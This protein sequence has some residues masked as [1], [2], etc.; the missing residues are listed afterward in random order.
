MTAAKAGA[1]PDPETAWTEIELRAAEAVVRRLQA[2]IVKATQAGRWNKVQALQHLLTHSHSAKILAVARVVENQGRKTPGVDGETWLTP[3]KQRQAVTRL[4]RRGYGPQPL[5]RVY[6]PKSNGQRRPLGIPTMLDRALQALYLQALD[7]VAET[8]ADPHSYGFRRGRS[9]H[10]ALEQCFNVLAGPKAPE[11]VLEGDIEACFDRLDHAW[12]LA[13]VP[14]RGAPL[15][16]WL[17][18]G[19]LERHVLHPTEEGCPQGG[20]I[21]PVLANLALDGLAATLAA[22]FPPACRQPSPKVHLVRYADDFVI[23]GPSR[24]VLEH[25]VR[26]VVEAFLAERGLRLSPTKTVITHIR[27]GFDFLGQNVRKYG[28][29]RTVPGSGKLL[30]RPSRKSIHRLLTD[31]RQWL[32]THAGATSEF[33]IAWFNPKL[34]G[35]ANYHGHG[36]SKATFNQIDHQM[37]GMLWRW[38]KRRHP[39]KNRTWIKAKYFTTV[40]GNRWV[41]FGKEGG[42]AGQ[43][44]YVLL[45][46]MGRTRITR[47]VKVRSRLNPYATEWQEYQEQRAHRAARQRLASGSIDNPTHEAWAAYTQSVQAR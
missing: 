21:S 10:D 2:R 39:Q 11:W 8:Q 40:G 33:V 15:Q 25:E 35:W 41:F 30:L 47:H 32:K 38:A 29:N 23:T 34:R 31:F 44:R 4:R 5:R 27:T 6:I 17:K 1:A 19:Y 12:L 9:C 16:A 22:R 20:I 45:Y 14:L 46:Q 13:H 36:A 3:A 37:V 24:A 42:K 7:P 18:A 26:P 43:M 28:G